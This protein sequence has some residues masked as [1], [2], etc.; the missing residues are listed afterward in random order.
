MLELLNELSLRAFT[1]K[2]FWERRSRLKTKQNSSYLKAINHIEKALEI[3][4]F[5]C[6]R[7]QICW[8]D[9]KKMEQ[10][11]CRGK[12]NSILDIRGDW[13]EVTYFRNTS[14]NFLKKKR[15]I[16]A[17]KQLGKEVKLLYKLKKKCNENTYYF[18]TIDVD[19]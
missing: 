18:F 3:L 5:H 9:K 16:W 1:K 12:I 8:A 13:W 14:T 19:N 4:S 11:T 17:G 2:T 10:I 6:I 15:K 7:E